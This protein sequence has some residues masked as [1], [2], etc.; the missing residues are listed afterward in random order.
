MFFRFFALL[1]VFSCLL[2][3][4]SSSNQ[5]QAEETIVDTDDQS[6]SIIQI[7]T[8]ERSKILEDNRYTLSPDAVTYFVENETENEVFIEPTSPY[9]DAYNSGNEFEIPLVAWYDPYESAED[10]AYPQ[11]KLYITNNTEE[12]LNI[13]QLDVVV[14]SSSIDKLPYVH[15]G[16]E[17][18]CSNNLAIVN[19][20]WYNWGSAKLDYTI[21]R[22]NEKFD[23]TYRG[24][25]TINYSE[26]IKRIDFTKEL[27]DMGYDYY[28]VK[29]LSESSDDDYI[30]LYIPDDDLN[31]YLDLF[32]PFEIGADKFDAYFGFARIHG[33]LTFNNKVVKFRGKLTLSTPAE[34]GAGMSENDAFDIKLSSEGSDYV[35]TKPYVTTINPGFGE[36]VVLTFMCEKSSNHRFVIKAKNEEGVE[37]IT[38]E[39][40]L[41]LL[42][43]RYSSK[44]IW[45]LVKDDYE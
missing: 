22:R 23:G 2:G 4:A 33:K 26:D 38:K 10:I 3:C 25:K 15:I 29:E 34:F 32:Y 28:S 18:S 31:E 17:E 41:H 44:R 14:E 13:S 9:Y 45:E 11:L 16:T 24:S 1:T 20:S 35:V 8:E 39:V 42:N 5:E 40:N 27:I 37:V 12:P 7:T 21:L 19:E 6:A 36:M 30:A 43:P